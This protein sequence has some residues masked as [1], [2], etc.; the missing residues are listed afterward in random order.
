LFPLTPETGSGVNPRVRA[1]DR[2]STL[3]AAAS[4]LRFEVHLLPAPPPANDQWSLAGPGDAIRSERVV[5][6]TRTPVSQSDIRILP[7]TGEGA[8]SLESSQ[9]LV[10]QPGIDQ[11]A[12]AHIRDASDNL[13]LRIG[14]DE[15]RQR[16][17]VNS[18]RVRSRVVFGQ[19]HED[20][21][22][23]RPHQSEADSDRL[24]SVHSGLRCWSRGYNEVV[25]LCLNRLFRVCEG[26]FTSST[27]A[28]T[29]NT[30]P[31]STGQIGA[32]LGRVGHPT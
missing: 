3:R 24:C 13:V 25:W 10:D 11:P 6:A 1:G 9:G 12:A 19:R 29:H 18:V 32:W 7:P 15:L 21:C 31:G 23:E 27:L 30:N 14:C 20:I 28:Q 26:T 5:P 22:F 4:G 17:S 8:H 16:E 2:S